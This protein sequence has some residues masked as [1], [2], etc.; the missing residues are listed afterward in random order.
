LGVGDGV[1]DDATD[2]VLDLSC[3]EW[4]AI[5]LAVDDVGCVDRLGLRHGVFDVFED[6]A[7]TRRSRLMDGR[8]RP[9]RGMW[10]S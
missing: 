7:G 2:E 4:E 10:M 5:A 8:L 9:I 6:T 3:G 1:V